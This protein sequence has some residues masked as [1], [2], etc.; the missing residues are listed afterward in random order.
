MGADT[1]DTVGYRVV[2]EY[3]NPATKGI[4]YKHLSRVYHVREA[5]EQFC[6]LAKITHKARYVQEVKGLA[7][8]DTPKRRSR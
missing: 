6:A 7:E 3:T 4:S 1:I 5:A 2:V 8:P